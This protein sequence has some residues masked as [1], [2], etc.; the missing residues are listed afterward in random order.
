MNISIALLAPLFSLSLLTPLTFP[1][2]A[3]DAPA[4]GIQ[5]RTTHIKFEPPAL[6]NAP[7]GRSR[8]G[9]SRGECPAATLPLTAIVPTVNGGV[10]GLTTADQPSFWFYVPYALNGDRSAE[11]VLLDDQNRYIYQT[12]LV[13]GESDAIGIT[14]VTLPATVVLEKDRLYQ[15]VFMVNCEIDNPIFTRGS[16]RKVTIDPV[17]STKIQQA[18]ALEQVRLYA[19]NGIWFEA[20]STLAELKTAK[21]G[22]AAIALEWKS[23][24]QSVDLTDI[25]DSPFVP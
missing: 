16:I 6:G 20:L 18:E 5:S 3:Q 12:T 7:G 17:L 24:L 1:A 23:L 13:N 19:E 22:D 14:Q 15:W 11:F 9:A 21:P 4:T 25:A 8:G 10:G 2:L